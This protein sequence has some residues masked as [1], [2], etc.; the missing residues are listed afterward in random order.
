MHNKDTHLD[1][2]FIT[3]SAGFQFFPWFFS[4]NFM[5]FNHVRSTVPR[6][7]PPRERSRDCRRRP[8]PSSRTR[9]KCICP[10][11]VWVVLDRKSVV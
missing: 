8:S 10:T 11:R 4:G 7:I 2:E 6:Y 9:R 1:I 5:I 3:S